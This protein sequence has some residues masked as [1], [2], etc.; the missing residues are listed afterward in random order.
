MRTQL[1]NELRSLSSRYVDGDLDETGVAR[2]AEL[3]AD[4]PARRAYVSQLT[5]HA[6]LQ[7][8]YGSQ[9][10]T[11]ESPADS[12]HV[13]T[14]ERLAE[15]RGRQAGRWAGWVQYGLVGLAASLLTAVITE[16]PVTGPAAED[17]VA[18]ESQRDGGPTTRKSVARIVRKID[19]DWEGDRWQVIPSSDLVAG[20]S[21]MLSKGLMELEF[22][23]GALVALEAPASFRV[24]SPLH[25]V[26]SHGKLTANVPESAHGFTVS[27]PR[28]EMIDLGT[29]FGLL[30]Q[31]DGTTETHV[32]GGEV[33]VRPT[34]VATDMHLTDKMAVRL[35]AGPMEPSRLA[36]VPNRFT[37]AKFDGDE[38]EGEPLIERALTLWFAADKRVQAD[39]QGRVTTWG[40]VPTAENVAAQDAWQVDPTKR[41]TL[42]ADA[43]G[44]KPALRFAGAQ[45]LVTEPTPLGSAQSLA[46]VFR[47]DMTARDK[48]WATSDAGRQLVNLNGPPHLV[49]G[50]DESDH[51]VSRTYVGSGRDAQG[52]PRVRHRRQ[53]PNADRT[54]R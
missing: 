21:V 30:V 11:S 24:E 32:F 17:R 46:I 2:L 16:R 49:L 33:V 25:A 1:V 37:Q 6:D 29:Q 44:G 54:P 36:A 8:L 9:S 39:E 10:L 14:H 18:E 3:L 15:H 45:F 48:P 40:D 19:C 4:E 28:G 38:D 26:L 13:T 7:L 5:S 12:D 43:I 52:P 50:I 20:Q 51:L 22:T 53:E 47:L 42:I 31:A 27:T 41:P 34:G 35:P 23:S